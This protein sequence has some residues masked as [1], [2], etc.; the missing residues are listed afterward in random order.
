[1]NY[2]LELGKHPNFMSFS[3]NLNQEIQIFQILG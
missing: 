2:K 1:L 3:Y